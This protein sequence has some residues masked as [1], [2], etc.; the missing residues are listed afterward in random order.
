MT[1]VFFFSK[2]GSW[3]LSDC[4]TVVFKH[5]LLAS[6][7]LVQYIKFIWSSNDLDLSLACFVY[8]HLISFKRHWR[9]LGSVYTL[10]YCGNQNNI[11]I[12]VIVSIFMTLSFSLAFCSCWFFIIPWVQH[13][14]VSI[15]DKLVRDFGCSSLTKSCFWVLLIWN[16][17]TVGCLSWRQT[18]PLWSMYKFLGEG[19]V[20]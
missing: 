2:M 7:Q 17:A 18:M 4:G 14:S 3:I 8:K 11:S 6:F 20:F 16:I 1:S 19:L 5:Q 12:I 9:V 15:T 10:W 13:W